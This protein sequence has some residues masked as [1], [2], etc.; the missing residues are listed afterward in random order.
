[1]HHL[2]CYWFLLAYFFQFQLLYLWVPEDQH[3]LVTRTRCSSC[4][5]CVRFCCGW[6]ETVV[7]ILVGG[8]VSCAPHPG[9]GATWAWYQ[10]RLRPPA[11]CN[12]WELPWRGA[13]SGQCYL[14]DVAVWEWHWGVLI[15]LRPFTKCGRVGATLQ[16]GSVLTW[17]FVFLF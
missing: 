7:G 15:Q 6:T 2:I 11:G 12:R 13:R 5:P 14:L 8:V 9:V 4:G 3:P 10:S 17:P 16:V 1:M